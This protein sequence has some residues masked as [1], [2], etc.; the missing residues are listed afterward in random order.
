MAHAKRPAVITAM[1]VLGMIGG[2]F[3]V[4]SGL[5][6]VLE[7]NRLGDLPN[8]GLTNEGLVWLGAITIALGS[9]GIYL[10]SS[11]LSG[12]KWTRVWYTVVGAV[13]IVTGFWLL[14]SHGSEAR[15]SG[16]TTLVLWVFVLQ[17]LYS[18]KA[19]RFF[20]EE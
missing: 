20:G 13:N 18:D 2:I 10:A 17:M 8:T 7:K 3:S 19:D 1:G 5:F 16:L 4:L 9:F 14:I 12:A 11:L 6:I 15:W